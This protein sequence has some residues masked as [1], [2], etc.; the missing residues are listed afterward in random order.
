MGYLITILVCAAIAIA[1]CWRMRFENDTRQARQLL[2]LRANLADMIR[3]N[4]IGDRV[5]DEVWRRMVEGESPEVLDNVK[6]AQLQMNP[7]EQRS[8]NRALLK[9]D[10]SMQAAPPEKKT[11]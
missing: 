9:V 10:R 4:W 3:Q 11:D 2:R 7:A 8:H 6:A 5:A 1:I